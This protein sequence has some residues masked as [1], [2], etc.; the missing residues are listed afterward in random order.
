MGIT[1]SLQHDDDETNSVD[2]IQHINTIKNQI[3]RKCDCYVAS[4]ENTNSVV[5]VKLIKLR[6]EISSLIHPLRNVPIIQKLGMLGMAA[7][8]EDI[9]NFAN[10]H[11][12]IIQR[13]LDILHESQTTFE[14]ISTTYLWPTTD[15]N[16]TNSSTTN[17]ED[18]YYLDEVCMNEIRVTIEKLLENYAKELEDLDITTSLKQK[19]CDE[20]QR[21]LFKLG[22]STINEAVNDF[23]YELKDAAIEEID[24]D[25]TQDMLSG[26]FSNAEFVKATLQH[27]I[28]KS[29]ITRDSLDQLPFSRRIELETAQDEIAAHVDQLIR[30]I[31][32]NYVHSPEEL[33]IVMNLHLPE[34]YDNNDGGT[35][36]H[37]END[38]ILI[39]NSDDDSDEFDQ[40]TVVEQLEGND[41]ED[42]NDDDADTEEE[43]EKKTEQKNDA[44]V[45]ESPNNHAVEDVVAFVNTVKDNIETLKQVLG[46][47]S[48]SPMKPQTTTEEIDVV[49]DLADDSESQPATNEDQQTLSQQAR[50]TRR[51]TV[52]IQGKS[53]NYS[54][55]NPPSPNDIHGSELDESDVPSERSYNTRRRTTRADTEETSSKRRRVSVNRNG[56]DVSESESVASSVASRSRRQTRVMEK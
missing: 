40:S 11:K 36:V 24:N 7:V 33:S 17:S 1:Q 46:P 15:L 21:L 12:H 18:L 48:G 39:G 25:L 45:T 37:I 52:E 16:V 38:Q 3:I 19:R 30:R 43:E 49:I 23:I 2:C 27:I 28:I 53:R 6:E 51:K 5:D 55:I 42:D 14:K 26:D 31:Q 9:E 44:N 10:T 13:L 4:I 54:R 35:S 8:L 22:E 56:G 29:T 20:L 41:E 47:F 32:L 34:D 50:R